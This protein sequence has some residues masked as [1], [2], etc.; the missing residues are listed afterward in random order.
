[1]ESSAKELLDSRRKLLKSDK[2]GGTGGIPTKSGGKK[3]CRDQNIRR[4]YW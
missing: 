3:D 2:A 1:M 4:V